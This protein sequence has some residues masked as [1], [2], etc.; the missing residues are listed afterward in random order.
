[1]LTRRDFLS[2]AA[3]AASIFGRVASAAAQQPRYDLL[4]RGGRV[5]DPSS[6]IDAI[7]DVAIAGGRIA[8]VEGSITASAADMFDAR[9]KLVVPGMLDIHTHVARSA[10]GAGLV[11]QDGVTG[12]IDAGT[13]GAERIADA[14]A[15]ARSAP[16]VGGVLI[17]IGRGGVVNGGETM[18]L[19]NADVAAA[20]DAIMGNREFI[21]GVKARLSRDV[22]GENDYEVL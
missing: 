2:G 4:I 8:A 9:G 10:E 17:N 5:I 14:I 13:Y 19:A 20:R 6:R 15:I 12:W 18:D 21:V 11:L 22:A 3:A 16:Q 7:R 1:M